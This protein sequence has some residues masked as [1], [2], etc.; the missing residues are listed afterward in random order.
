MKLRNRESSM[1]G[2]GIK[3]DFTSLPFLRKGDNI[4]KISRSLRYFMFIGAFLIILNC[5]TNIYLYLKNRQENEKNETLNSI[6]KS[7]TTVLL[8]III[9]LIALLLLGGKV[10]WANEKSTSASEEIFKWIIMTVILLTVGIMVNKDLGTWF[11]GINY[12]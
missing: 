4:P 12:F 5:I 11:F 2:G 3:D 1:Y 8:I 9:T 10:D 7:Q 6:Y